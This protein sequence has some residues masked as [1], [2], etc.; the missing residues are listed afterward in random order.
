MSKAAWLPPN[1]LMFLG[2]RIMAR[3]AIVP[4]RKRFLR[5]LCKAALCEVCVFRNYCSRS[6]VVSEEL[7]VLYIPAP[8]TTGA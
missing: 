5:D 4:D 1:S 7:Q 2:A 3:L 6:E 8:L